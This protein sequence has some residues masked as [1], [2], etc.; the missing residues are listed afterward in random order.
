[1]ERVPKRCCF[2]ID[3]STLGIKREIEILRANLSFRTSQYR[4]AKWLEE[5]CRVSL[6][7]R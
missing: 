3:L 1:M 4:K 6:E 7:E 5:R 2:G